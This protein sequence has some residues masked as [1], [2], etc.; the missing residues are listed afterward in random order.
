[1]NHS[2][3]AAEWDAR[4][5]ASEQVW[6]GRVNRL[7]PEEIKHLNP[8]TA[9]DVGSGEGAD[10]VWLATQGWKVTGVDISSVAVERARGN[11]KNS[12][13]SIDFRAEDISTTTGS[14]DLVSAFYATVLQET[15]M[16]D[17]IL[18]LVAPGGTLIFVHHV[19]PDDE[20]PAGYREHRPGFT[21]PFDVLAVLE[22]R[23]SGQPA[24]GE[25][26]IDRFEIIDNGESQRH[27]F[28]AI[29][30]ATRL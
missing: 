16:L 11:A 8:G 5:A 21:S 26:R 4:Y 10:A 24:T 19:H 20:H 14:F 15:D 3:M 18:E 30:R 17:H 13:V 25:W 2:N 27:R 28:D 29:L 22:R 9:L 6:S 7:L 12:G 23:T 1:M